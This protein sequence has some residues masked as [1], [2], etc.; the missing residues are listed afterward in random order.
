VSDGGEPG[1]ASEPETERASCRQ[2]AVLGPPADEATPSGETGGAGES[3]G[4]W[5]SWGVQAA[6]APASPAS[7]RPRR[8]IRSVTRPA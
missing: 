8:P 7:T 3:R 2:S 1:R 5:A 4:G 6:A